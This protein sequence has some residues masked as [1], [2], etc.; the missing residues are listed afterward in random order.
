MPR[1]LGFQG[2]ASTGLEEGR[3]D[4]QKGLGGGNP[5]KETFKLWVQFIKDNFEDG[6]EPA[7]LEG[8]PSFSDYKDRAKKGAGP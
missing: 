3:E 1:F 6:G 7:G 5:K 8:A 2:Q 4:G